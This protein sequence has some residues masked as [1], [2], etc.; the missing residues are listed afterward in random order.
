[1]HKI[2]FF[3]FL[4]IGL[5]SLTHAQT[6]RQIGTFDEIVISGN[7]DVKL[8]QSETNEVHLDDRNGMDD[9]VNISIQGRRLKISLLDGWLRQNNSTVRVLV[10]YERLVDIKV[11]A[12]AE[13]EVSETI[14]TE[15]LAVKVGSGAELWLDV[16]TSILDGSASEGG[17][18][19]ISGTTRYQEASAA[20]GGIYDASELQSEETNVRANTG[21]EA[22][23]VATRLLDAVANTGGQVRYL[24]DPEEKYTRSNLAGEIRGY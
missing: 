23:V 11:L 7:L 3:L 1:M 21:G 16:N 2:S 13:V 5:L 4:S 6:I 18:L 19:T 8:E 10:R 17:E 14:E 24:G 15:K 22:T 20:T 12:G 9:A